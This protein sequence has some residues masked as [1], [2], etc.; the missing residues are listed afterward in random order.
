MRYKR[1]VSR[2][3]QARLGWWV[4]IALGLTLWGLFWASL[5]YAGDVAEVIA[6]EACSEGPSGM[7]A[8]ANTIK[9]RAKIA[10]ITPV[11]VVT[12]KNQYYGLTNKNRAKIY[13]ECRETA[14]YLEAH[15]NSIPDI[16]GGATYFLLPGERRRAWHKTFTVKIG[17]HSFYK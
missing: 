11:A 16:T 9:N 4:A 3:R 15:I 14:D 17:K 7:Q 13:R 1:L 2:S 10:H 5:A 8:V 6:A 12:A